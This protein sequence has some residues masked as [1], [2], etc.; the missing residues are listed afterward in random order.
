MRIRRAF[1]LAEIA[2]AMSRGAYNLAKISTRPPYRAEEPRT[3]AVET[4]RTNGVE[5]RGRPASLLVEQLEGLDDFGPM[6]TAED[7][8]Q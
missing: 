5:P 3:G 7:Q 1:N 6:L 8:N 4:R 2:A